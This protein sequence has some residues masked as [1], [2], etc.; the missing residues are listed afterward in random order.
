VKKGRG[1]TAIGKVPPLRKRLENVTE[2]RLDLFRRRSTLRGEVAGVELC[3]L[4]GEVEP[5]REGARD[6]DDDGSEVDGEG[7]LET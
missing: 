5:S 4:A 6:D 1:K 3:V 2:A 7:E